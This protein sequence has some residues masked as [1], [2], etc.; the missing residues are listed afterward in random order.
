MYAWPAMRFMFSS[1]SAGAPTWIF[2]LDFFNFP[3]K[4]DLKNK[5]YNFI[6]GGIYHHY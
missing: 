2:S 6:A 3:G 4:K 1:G 5:G